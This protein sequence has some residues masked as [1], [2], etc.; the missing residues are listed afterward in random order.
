MSTVFL[1]AI[2]RRKVERSKDEK[3]TYKKEKNRVTLITKFKEKRV[4]DMVMNTKKQS[5]EEFV[6]KMG[7]DGKG[8]HKLFFRVLKSL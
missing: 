5:L 2:F 8:N 4:K 6:E 7:M 1:K 3:N